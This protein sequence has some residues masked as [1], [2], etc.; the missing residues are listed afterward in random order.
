MDI[1]KSVFNRIISISGIISLIVLAVLYC[2]TE[3]SVPTPVYA[4]AWFGCIAAV[5]AATRS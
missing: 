5:L 3:I 2:F 1:R 4:A